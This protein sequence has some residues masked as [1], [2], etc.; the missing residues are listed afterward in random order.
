VL[1]IS[2]VNGKQLVECDVRV[3]FL[4]EFRMIFSAVCRTEAHDELVLVDTALPQDHPRNLRRVCLPLMCHDW[5]PFVDDRETSLGALDK[6]RS[7]I[8]DPTQ[9]IRTMHFRHDDRH[10]YIR[11]FFRTQALIEQACSPS[12]DRD[13][14]WDEWGR[15]SVILEVPISAG[16]YTLVQGPRVI[17]V[18]QC[19]V[20]GSH[21]IELRLRTFD[22]RLRACGTL[23]DIGEGGESVRVA[24]HEHGRDLLLE[25]TEEIDEYLFD[26]LGDGIF[27]YPVSR[28]C[29]WKKPVG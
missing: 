1:D 6:H 17:A 7:L 8:V 14:P 19:A 28:L 24:R 27:F 9:A 20:P 21:R 22:F 12:T 5:A 26:S 16:S 10:R 4:D 3:T 11:L 23:S 29:S 13:I 15:G 2:S 18:E 25:G